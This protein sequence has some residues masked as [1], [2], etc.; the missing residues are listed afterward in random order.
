MADTGKPNENPGN[1]KVEGEQWS[2]EQ[3]S[4]SKAEQETPAENY[5]P[6]DGDNAGGQAKAKRVRR[7]NQ[8]DPTAERSTDQSTQSASGLGLVRPGP[9]PEV[10]KD[11]LNRHD[12]GRYDTPRRS[13]T[14]NDKI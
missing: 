14:E 11:L 1:S 2:S 7:A 13:E 8:S 4:V 5:P 6:D 9:G 10:A 12:E 3:N